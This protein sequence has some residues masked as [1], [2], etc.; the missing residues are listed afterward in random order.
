MVNP[1]GKGIAK[2]RK[3]MGKDSSLV[4][5]PPK[6]YMA[7]PKMT[8]IKEKPERKFILKKRLKIWIKSP[9]KKRVNPRLEGMIGKALIF[10]FFCQIRNKEIKG[11]KNP[12]V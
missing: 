8:A 6:K 1:E 4:I 3:R 11:S 5:L 10:S 12:C 9:A 2:I 7:R